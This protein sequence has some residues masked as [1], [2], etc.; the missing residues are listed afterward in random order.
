[1]KI[2]I[3]AD[4]EAHF[5]LIEKR[6]RFNLPREQVAGFEP[7][8][9]LLPSA[10]VHTLST[11][12]VKGKRKSKKDKLREATARAQNPKPTAA[13]ETVKVSPW[14]SHPPFAKREK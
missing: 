14:P 8:E 3:S 7:K 10:T 13:I 11:G 6:N 12:G 2:L 5:R 9:S 1:M 4:M